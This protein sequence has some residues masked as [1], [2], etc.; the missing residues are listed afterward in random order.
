MRSMTYA[1]AGKWS[2][3]IANMEWA[4]TWGYKEKKT[5]KRK[6]PKKRGKTMVPHKQQ[7]NS[8]TN[9][10]EKIVSGHTWEGQA[11]LFGDV[12]DIDSSN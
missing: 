4:T 9:W 1:Y 6:E 12:M 8:E 10:K 11:L 7:K 5:Q 2:A 3:N